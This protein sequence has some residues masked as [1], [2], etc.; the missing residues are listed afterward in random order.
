[1]LNVAICED[2]EREARDAARRIAASSLDA[3]VTCM[4]TPAQLL[5]RYVPGTW[6]LIV[7]D[8]FFRRTGTATEEPDGVE[9]VRRIRMLDPDVPIAFATSS[10]D[11]ALEAY[12]LGV[13]RYLEKPITQ[14]SADEVLRMAADARQVMPGVT[15][16]FPEGTRHIPARRIMWCEQNSH[17]VAIHLSD[18]TTE[19]L[20]VKLS[21]I[22]DKLRET[23][24]SRLF[25]HCH[26]SYLVNLAFVE[27]VDRSLGILRMSD[28]GTVHV[29]RG[30]IAHVYHLWQQWGFQ[31]AEA[32]G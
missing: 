9:A 32:R 24:S 19:E 11:Y 4:P 16:K 31:L 2:Q 25:V 20:R 29:R 8:I 7:M 3:H 12:R 23:S 30:D 15:L 1:M 14:S 27:D 17:S 18:G 6:D 26:K 21:E 10:T 22:V 5:E 13:S 28:G